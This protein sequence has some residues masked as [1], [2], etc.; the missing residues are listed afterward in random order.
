MDN[1]IDKFKLLWQQA[2]EQASSKYANAICVSTVDVDGFPNSRFVDLKDVNHDGFIF[3]TDLNSPKA[4]DIIRHPKVSLTMWWEHIGYQIRI[5]GI[6]KQIPDQ[7]ADYYWETR[8][9]GARLTTLTF[10]QSQKMMSIDEMT[11]QYHHAEQQHL[12]QQLL[13]PKHWSGFNLLPV[14][15][16][17]LAFKES[18]LHIRTA[19]RHHANIQRWEKFFLQP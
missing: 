1:P 2:K 12:N 11:E 18:R 4:L 6:C 8:P 7:L 9:S 14:Y 17:F 5:Q 15:I 19:Y 16:E 13:R 10:N 3:C